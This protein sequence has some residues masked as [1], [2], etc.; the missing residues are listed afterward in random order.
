MP[1]AEQH[2]A[3]LSWV[4]A[5]LTASVTTYAAHWIDFGALVIVHMGSAYLVLKHV[6]PPSSR[7]RRK[8]RPHLL[9]RLWKAL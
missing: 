9:A 8:R 6:F 3:G 7:R 1:P 5:L 2:P 4:V